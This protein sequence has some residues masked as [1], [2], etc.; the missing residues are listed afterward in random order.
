MSTLLKN[1]LEFDR[2]KLLGRGEVRREV[3]AERLIGTDM[4]GQSTLGVGK[5]V[6]LWLE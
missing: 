3:K 4:Q 5:V 1:K 2:Q 6:P